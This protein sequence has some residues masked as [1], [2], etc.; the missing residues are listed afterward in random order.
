MNYMMN[1]HILWIKWEKLLK[2]EKRKIKKLLINYNNLLKMKLLNLKL[3][4]IIKFIYLGSNK[5][6]TILLKEYKPEI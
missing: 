2:K 3:E 5:K 6:K 4:V 1:F